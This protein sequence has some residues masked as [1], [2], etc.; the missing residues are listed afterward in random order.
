MVKEYPLVKFNYA[1]LLLLSYET[2]EN[3]ASPQTSSLQVVAGQVSTDEC[4]DYVD[5]CASQGHTDIQVS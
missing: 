5:E 2:Q 4:T 3:L 1:F